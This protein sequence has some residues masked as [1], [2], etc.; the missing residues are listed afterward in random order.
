[1]LDVR[2]F[3]PSEVAIDGRPIEVDTRKAIAL[4]AYLVVE[5]SATRDALAGLLWA[6]SS[7]ERARATLRRTLSALRGAAGADLI[8]ADRSLVSLVGATSADVDALTTDLEETTGHGHDPRDVCDRCIPHLR[9]ATDLYRAAG[10]VRSAGD[11]RSHDQWL[12]G[13]GGSHE[14]SV[15]LDTDGCRRARLVERVPTDVG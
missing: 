3:G 9:R 11:D 7:Q 1:M 12:V 14:V 10:N 8:E 4:L 6:D 2:L 13:V 15:R 5:K